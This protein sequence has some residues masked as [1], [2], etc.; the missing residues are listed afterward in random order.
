[1]ATAAGDFADLA[2]RM[3][4]PKSL[5]PL[6][7]WTTT[8]IDNRED[9]N[10]DSNNNN[11]NL[12]TSGRGSGSFANECGPGPTRCPGGPVRIGKGI[13]TTDKKA[14]K[15]M[16]RTTSNNCNDNVAI[17]R[18]LQQQ[19]R[20]ATTLKRRKRRA[21]IRPRSRHGLVA[22]ALPKRSLGRNQ[23]ENIDAFEQQCVGNVWYT[24][25]FR[26]DALYLGPS[27]SAFRIRR[28][29]DP[30]GTS[31]RRIKISQLSWKYCRPR[32]LPKMSSSN[33]NNN[34]NNSRSTK[35]NVSV[36]L[37]VEPQRQM[38]PE[39]KLVDQVLNEDD[40]VEISAFSN[41]YLIFWRSIGATTHPPCRLILLMIGRTNER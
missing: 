29:F 38:P 26:R 28:R 12:T 14:K 31:R 8:T 7:I 27:R 10:D 4:C 20:V 22:R 25:V 5:V 6:T 35:S 30:V 36:D 11:D 33:N 19:L 23:N 1:M 2:P 13:A 34:N 16:M 17:L 37:I 3:T 15:I 9:N 39:H 18:R 41:L 40:L 32:K 21:T 24:E